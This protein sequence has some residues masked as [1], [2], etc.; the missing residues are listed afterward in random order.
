[1]SPVRAWKRDDFPLW[2]RPMMPTS[3][4]DIIQTWGKHGKSNGIG[5]RFHKLE[6]A[7]SIFSAAGPENPDI[8]KSKL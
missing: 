3:I 7:I 2:G 1:M 5:H 6:E 8:F 4:T